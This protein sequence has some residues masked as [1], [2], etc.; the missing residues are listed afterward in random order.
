[1]EL[2]SLAER[3]SGTRL[4][5]ESYVQPTGQA[6]FLG[7]SLRDPY[8]EEF[9]T[10]PPLETVSDLYFRAPIIHFEGGFLLAPK[11]HPFC[12]HIQPGRVSDTAEGRVL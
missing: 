9:A 5:P 10:S 3:R 12:Y 1:M 2:G 6:S 4:T 8:L 7:E 11:S